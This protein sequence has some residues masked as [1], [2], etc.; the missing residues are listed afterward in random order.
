MSKVLGNLEDLVGLKL[1]TVDTSKG[2]TVIDVNACLE[3]VKNT[4]KNTASSKELLDQAT[5]YFDGEDVYLPPGQ[6]GLSIQIR[7]NESFVVTRAYL[8]FI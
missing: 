8:P 4:L 7:Y 3:L 6:Y 2:Y 1:P 5:V